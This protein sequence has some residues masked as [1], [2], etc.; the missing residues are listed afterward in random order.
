MDAYTAWHR[1]QLFKEHAAA[2][3]TLSMIDLKVNNPYVQEYNE[4]LA[5]CLTMIKTLKITDTDVLDKHESVTKNLVLNKRSTSSVRSK[6][7]YDEMQS[8]LNDIEV[9]LDDLK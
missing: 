2:L 6:H 4:L 1:M 5:Y 3:V 7:M 9:I 8:L